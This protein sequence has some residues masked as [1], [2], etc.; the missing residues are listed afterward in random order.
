MGRPILSSASRGNPKTIFGAS[1]HH[2]DEGG[3]LLVASGWFVTIL[4]DV[5]AG[6]VSPAIVG[7]G[8]ALLLVLGLTR[9]VGLGVNL[10]FEFREE[11]SETKMIGV[12]GGDVDVMRSR[13]GQRWSESSRWHRGGIAS[14]VG[15][16]G[17]IGVVVLI[18][19]CLDGVD[20]GIRV[21]KGGRSVDDVEIGV[22]GL[23]FGLGFDEMGFEVDPGFFGIGA[24][25]PGAQIRVEDF[26]CLE[27][28][29]GHVDEMRIS[30][31]G[32]EGG[33]HVFESF[34]VGKDEG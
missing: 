21:A 30:L 9:F 24:L 13:F 1:T 33:G 18:E 6:T 2:V 26:C 23:E 34:V 22:A 14:R 28:G 11:I 5:A 29:S 3:V 10:G 25:V 8:F 12:S 20:A 4:A 16:V 15:G 7:D 17:R 32:T 31:V 19:E 27:H